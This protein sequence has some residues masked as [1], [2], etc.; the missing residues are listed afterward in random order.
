[1]DPKFH[2]H[3]VA[4]R[5]EVINRIIDD[6][7]GVSITFPKLASNDVVF[8]KGDKTNVEEAKRKIEEIVKDLVNI[9]YFFFFFM[10][11]CK[12]VLLIK[13]YLF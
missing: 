9:A 5:G 8:I 6:C 13:C 12:V 2:R 11:S 10:N 7:N 1:M 4:R 3:F